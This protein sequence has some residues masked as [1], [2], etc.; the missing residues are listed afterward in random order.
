VADIDNGDAHYVKLPEDTNAFC[1]SNGSQLHGSDYHGKR[2]QLICINP[3]FSISKYEKLL[4]RSIE[5]Y[6]DQLNY[7]LEM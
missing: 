7:K 4:D 2:K 3:V 6:R 5:K 1:W